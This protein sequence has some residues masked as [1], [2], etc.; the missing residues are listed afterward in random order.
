MPYNPRAHSQGR[1]GARD[2]RDGRDGRDADRGGK[3]GAVTRAATGA[4]AALPGAY[5]SR[6]VPEKEDKEAPKKKKPQEAKEKNE[7]TTGQG[8]KI[9]TYSTGSSGTV[10]ER[11]MSF[12]DM[13]RRASEKKDAAPPAR[14]TTTIINDRGQVINNEADDDAH[15]TAYGQRPGEK[16][17][18]RSASASSGRARQ[19]R[20]PPMS[21]EVSRR[22]KHDDLDY[23]DELTNWQQASKES[24]P[25][26]A[27]A[28]ARP[29]DDLDFP[30][31]HLLSKAA[32]NGSAAVAG[33]EHAKG[34]KE[35]SISERKAQAKATRDAALAAAVGN[36]ASGAAPP[37]GASP[38]RRSNSPGAGGKA[39]APRGIVDGDRG[40]DMSRP[41]DRPRGSSP[42]RRGNSPA[43]NRS[44][45]VERAAAMYE[46][47]S[48]TVA[49]S[50]ETTKTS[51]KSPGF[52]SFS[53]EAADKA[54]QSTAAAAAASSPSPP[55]AAAPTPTPAATTTAATAPAAPKPEA[56]GKS[57]GVQSTAGKPAP[58][59]KPAAAA[60]ERAKP[61]APKPKA[62]AKDDAK[63]AAAA[64]AAAAAPQ[65][66]P[67]QKRRRR[68][69]RK[70]SRRL[71]PAAPRRPTRTPTRSRRRYRPFPYARG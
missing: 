20:E 55:A 27:P 64:A 17:K 15:R 12:A 19:E 53:G 2:G 25:L 3:K 1:G 69:R 67:P 8:V 63:P 66:K 40:R 26:F 50:F 10:S 42:G 30:E 51:K 49:L 71:W 48:D 62:A 43:R 45:S 7:V 24:T 33:A 18:R 41:G 36:F 11:G 32:P 23:D 44:P 58:A 54:L 39:A 14:P 47:Q 34:A 9:V 56:A 21:T 28:E 35:P 52:F 68:R 59:A 46:G 6:G 29:V 57:A 65:Q 31:F 5:Q 4:R 13:L 60:V 38:H 37:R 22:A 16:E 70:P 61:A